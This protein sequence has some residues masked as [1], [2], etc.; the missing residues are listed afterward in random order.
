LVYRFLV[1]NV[2]WSQQLIRAVW[3]VA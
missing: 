3:G 2:E 1:R